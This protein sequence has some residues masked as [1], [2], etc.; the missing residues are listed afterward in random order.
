M[1]RLFG[2]LLIGISLRPVSAE[3]ISK[4]D[5]EF[6]MSALHASRK[7]FLDA[8]AGLS[9]AQLSFKPAP[10]KW[11]IAEIAEHVALSEQFIF[12]AS[13]A[14]VKSPA[15]ETMADPGK[16]DEKILAAVPDRTVKVTAPEPL[17]P[18]N[19]FK[20]T[21]EAVAA[22]KSSL[23]A[24][25]EYLSETQGALRAHLLKNPMMGDLDAYQWILLMSAHTE[26]HVTQILE[27]K[28]SPGFPQQ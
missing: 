22:F 16:T 27:V 11:S 15:R 18:Q 26:R 13:E 14:A 20:S 3:P 6:G 24:H 23:D 12:Q 10:E 17:R 21:A 8:V 19:R 4:G 9:D 2:V 5:R 28:A 7:L 1:R 25:I